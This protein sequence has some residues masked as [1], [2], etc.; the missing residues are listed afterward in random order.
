MTERAGGMARL[1]RV[2]Q[3]Q[4]KSY[5]ARCRRLLASRCCDSTV[6]H[7]AEPALSARSRSVMARAAFPPQFSSWAAGKNPKRER[8]MRWRAFTAALELRLLA[9]RHHALSRERR[10]S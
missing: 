4:G 2:A 10:P 6:P 5:A 8:R 9:T 3:S 7:A 1:R